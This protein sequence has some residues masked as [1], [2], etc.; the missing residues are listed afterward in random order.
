MFQ[1]V[2][3]PNV[4]C[5]GTGSM[6][7][8]CY[9]QDECTTKN[10]VSIG[11][12][13]NGFGVCCRVLMSCG[14]RSAENLTIF[15]D[16][17]MP[18]GMGNCAA[19]IAP[20]NSEVRQL[21]LDFERFQ[22]AGPSTDPT[23][24]AMTLNGIPIRPPI[25]GTP[26]IPMVA[27]S[28]VGQCITDRFV[29]S[30]GS[31]FG[32]PV[33][34]GTNTGAHL[35]VDID[36]PSNILSFQFGSTPSAR[37]FQIRITQYEMDS[38]NLAPKGCTQYFASESGTGMVQTFNF[39]NGHLANQNQVMCVRQNQNACRICWTTASPDDFDVSGSASN[40]LGGSSMVSS[41]CGPNVLGTNKQGLDCLSLPLA[42]NFA[43]TK[44]LRSRFC[45]R[46]SGL[47]TSTTQKL[48]VCSRVAPFQVTF[49]SDSF[50]NAPTPTDGGFAE[51]INIDQGV[52]LI[53]F[54]DSVNCA[55]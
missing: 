38:P 12:C 32:P 54:Q 37:S 7:G 45:G 47:T 13:A 46:K 29:V 1:V 10:G 22:I 33:I 31:A 24:V 35:Y 9:T 51:A 27:S 28:I 30:S 44:N 40:G 16:S 23:V 48:T 50:E 4:E 17:N 2:Q 34:C 42:E 26:P 8:T 41:C 49:R 11:S 20:A 25:P 3:F 14:A 43:G 21:R 18:T 6:T 5:N 52:K 19:E 36:T 39:G 53:Y 15:S 55:N